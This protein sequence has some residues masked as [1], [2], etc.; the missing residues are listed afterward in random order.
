MVN[1]AQGDLPLPAPGNN[2]R[3]ASEFLPRF[4]RTQANN[5]FLQATLD[6]LIQ[7]GVAEKI[8]GYYGRRNAKAYKSSDNYISDVS[9]EREN[10]QLEPSVVIKDDLD[11]VTFYK[12]YNDFVNQLEYFGSNTV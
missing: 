10:R 1:N 12:D 7:P 5:K 2:K 9:S 11:N 3:T 8:N 4:F 6:Q